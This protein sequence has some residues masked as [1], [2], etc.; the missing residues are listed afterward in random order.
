[1]KVIL[2]ETQVRAMI[3]YAILIFNDF[4]VLLQVL[5]VSDK[6]FTFPQRHLDEALRI[7]TMTK[8]PN[9]VEKKRN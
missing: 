4:F 7:F 6:T 8:K 5:S 1:L 2:A 3:S 9:I